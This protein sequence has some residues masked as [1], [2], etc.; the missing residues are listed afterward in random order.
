MRVIQGL[1]VKAASLQVGDKTLSVS[2]APL[3][4]I[5]LLVRNNYTLQKKMGSAAWE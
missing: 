4:S 1:Q 3:P 5:V 2:Q